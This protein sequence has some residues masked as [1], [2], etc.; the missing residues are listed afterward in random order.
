MR[1]QRKTAFRLFDKQAKVAFLKRGLLLSLVVVS[2]FWLCGRDWL[3]SSV[4]S[5]PY[6]VSQLD[7][8]SVLLGFSIL[9]GCSLLC[10]HAAASSGLFLRRLWAL[11]IGAGG[12]VSL[13]TYIPLPAAHVLLLYHAVPAVPMFTLALALPRVLS[14]S[15]WP[16]RQNLVQFFQ[17]LKKTLRTPLEVNSKLKIDSKINP[18]INSALTLT[19]KVSVKVSPK[20]FLAFSQLAIYKLGRAVSFFV[21][22]SVSPLVQ[23][24]LAVSAALAACAS[25]ALSSGYRVP[26]GCQPVALLITEILVCLHGIRW[27][28]RRQG[29]ALI[30]TPFMVLIFSALYLISPFASRLAPIILGGT[31]SSNE[32]SSE[33][34]LLNWLLGSLIAPFALSGLLDLVWRQKASPKEKSNAAENANAVAA[35][36]SATKEE[37]L[38]EK[39]LKG[40]RFSPRLIAFAPVALVCL[41]LEAFLSSDTPAYVALVLWAGSV[42]LCS[43]TLPDMLTYMNEVTKSYTK[44]N[45]ARWSRYWN[46]QVDIR[47]DVRRFCKMLLSCLTWKIGTSSPLATRNERGGIYT[48]TSS[49]QRSSTQKSHTK[50]TY[51]RWPVFEKI[52]E[53][54]VG[55]SALRPG[56]GISAF[57]V[58]MLQGLALAVGIFGLI[59]VPNGDAHTSSSY[60][61]LW[62]LVAVVFLQL[63][64]LPRAGKTTRIKGWIKC[65]VLTFV[66]LLP[67]ISFYGTSILSFSSFLYSI[68]AYN[69][70]MLL[71]GHG[72][73][74][75]PLDGGLEYIRDQGVI[76]WLLM[77]AILAWGISRSAQVLT[78]EAA[79]DSMKESINADGVEAIAICS[80]EDDK[81]TGENKFQTENKFQEAKLLI[82]EEKPEQ[83]PLVPS[84]SVWEKTISQSDQRATEKRATEKSERLKAEQV[85]VEQ[86]EAAKLKVKEARR[87][88]TLIFDA[89]DFPFALDLFCAAAT[90]IIVMLYLGLSFSSPGTSLGLAVSLGILFAVGY[91]PHARRLENHTSGAQKP[92]SAREPSNTQAPFSIQKR[93]RAA[94]AM[95]LVIVAGVCFLLPALLARV[96]AGGFTPSKPADYIAWQRLPVAVRQTTQASVSPLMT[97]PEGHALIRR[98]FG[99]RLDTR[100]SAPA[101][102]AARITGADES[103]NPFR[104]VAAALLGMQ[105]SSATSLDRLFELYVN[106][107]DYGH[108]SGSSESTIGISQASQQFFGTTPSEMTTAQT[109]FLLNSPLPVNNI[110]LLENEEAVRFAPAPS[111]YSYTRFS[112]KGFPG[113][114]GWEMHSG[115]LNNKGVYASYMVEASSPPYVSSL[116]SARALDAFA[117]RTEAWA[118]NDLGEATGSSGHWAAFW[119]RSGNIRNLGMLP[120]FVSC[121]AHAIN[122]HSAVAGYAWNSDAQKKDVSGFEDT[123]HAF[124]WS[125]GCMHDLGVPD[126]YRSSRAYALNNHGQVAGWLLTHSGQ[127]HAMVWQNGVFHD[128]GAFPG[129]Q[130][131]VANAINDTGMVVGS[132]QH[133]D[134]T[135]TACLWQNGRILDLGRLP[136][137]MYS[138]AL[139]INNLGQV[140]GESRLDANLNYP[141][142]TAF[143]W[144]ARHGVRDLT[145]LFAWDPVWRKRV[146]HCTT[147]LSINDHQKILGY[148]FYETVRAPRY[149]FLLIPVQDHDGEP[150]A[151]SVS[152]VLARAK[153]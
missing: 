129:G 147:A 55:R 58:F 33:I 135:V 19:R 49:T 43:L 105:L 98:C 12:V 124:L 36:K 125:H 91:K 38:K 61:G 53:A 106:L 118:V 24:L 32:V 126:G 132:A 119:D 1:V 123:A 8:F 70:R 134:G 104:S 92:S 26:P 144:D 68:P 143:L 85:K 5:Y 95:C 10:G 96:I 82:R 45:D 107:Q 52:R 89:N 149:H 81:R 115:V 101:I 22:G 63:F 79:A 142:G 31:G 128:L 153:G 110:S 145:P 51:G 108:T 112:M 18:R 27:L 84:W 113:S 46:E 3:T 152:R 76:S 114:G 93:Q 11:L 137:D 17:H 141:G 73:L 41:S 67:Y 64:L 47:G 56:H 99:A 133:Q 48:Q 90:T 40:E 86:L 122:N 127:T 117:V 35:E 83:K 25:L 146:A 13:L 120:G 14:S 65:A 72:L 60:L 66:C 62:A 75:F 7:T 34:V 16:T 69:V 29:M 77:G 136:G 74:Q 140:V 21:A 23:W 50:S 148:G 42:V 80:P 87:H 103:T 130:T 39:S 44:S 28:S 78:T 100:L 6:T 9:A 15:A 71:L 57:S 111:N 97:W 54:L 102:V 4:E 2:A 139:G 37:G 88:A 30:P 150:A 116:K 109:N 121:A 131:S 94:L 138:R 20:A 151:K 59:L